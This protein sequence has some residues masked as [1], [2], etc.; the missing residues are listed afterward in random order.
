[1]DVAATYPSHTGFCA[2]GHKTHRAWGT[3]SEEICAPHHGNSELMGG[4]RT[5]FLP[6]P[7]KQQNLGI[8]ALALTYPSPQCCPQP[9][10]GAARAR[11]RCSRAAEDN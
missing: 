4:E 7:F 8:I 10:L 5:I 9:L 6:A 11:P 1:M 3:R 2:C